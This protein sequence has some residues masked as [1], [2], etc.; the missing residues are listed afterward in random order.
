[1][2]IDFC[3]CNMKLEICLSVLTCDW[4]FIT[5]ELCPQ[6]ETNKNKW[7]GKQDEI[8]TGIFAYSFCAEAE[9]Y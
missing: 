9:I 1:M 5:G 2:E 8:T 3:L 7:G 6:V 4:F